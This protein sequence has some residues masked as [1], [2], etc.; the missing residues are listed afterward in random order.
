MELLIDALH[1]HLQNQNVEII[2]QRDRVYIIVDGRRKFFR[3]EE[4]ALEYLG[5]NK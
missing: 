5:L 1:K 3:T 2:H 4:E